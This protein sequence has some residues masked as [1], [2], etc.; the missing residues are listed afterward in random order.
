MDTMTIP[1]FAERPPL[2]ALQLD[3]FTH[4]YRLD[5]DLLA[6]VAAVMRNAGLGYARPAVN[7]GAEAATGTSR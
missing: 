3:R 4:M 6:V 7:F 1:A 5:A 2:I